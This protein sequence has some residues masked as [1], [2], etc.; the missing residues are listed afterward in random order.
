MFGG[1]A[2]MGSVNGYQ[3]PALRRGR[4]SVYDRTV[5]DTWQKGLTWVE[6]KLSFG[7]QSR[8]ADFRWTTLWA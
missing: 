8:D 3:R 2:A 7:S 4:S 5:D 1:V 6:V